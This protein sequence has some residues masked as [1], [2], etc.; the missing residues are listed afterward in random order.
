VAASF[1]QM[2]SSCSITFGEKEICL[3]GVKKLPFWGGMAVSRHSNWHTGIVF[4]QLC[5]IFALFS[6][7]IF[8]KTD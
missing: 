6:M 3:R 7:K 8:A 5:L 4:D 2:N 1:K